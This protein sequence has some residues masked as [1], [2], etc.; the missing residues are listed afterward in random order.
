MKIII[1]N[2]LALNKLHSVQLIYPLFSLDYEFFSEPELDL[3]LNSETKGVYDDL[4]H[5]KRI[6]ELDYTSE[7]MKEVSEFQR[8]YSNLSRLESVSLYL[9]QREEAGIFA[10]NTLVRDA[11]I[12]LG[13]KVYGYDWFFDQLSHHQIFPPMDVFNK[14]KDLEK[15]LYASTDTTRPECVV[16]FY[17]GNNQYDRTDHC[18][19][20]TGVRKSKL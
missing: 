12:S 14:W 15:K 8:Q 9:A 18:I 20:N 6:K 13:I 7:E 16:A 2:P 17:N 5:Y 11:A 3:H 10:T 1:N 19:A 4:L